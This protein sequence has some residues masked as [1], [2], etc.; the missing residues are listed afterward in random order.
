[1]SKLT[2]TAKRLALEVRSAADDL[3]VS[4]CE[5][6]AEVLRHMLLSSDCD[7]CH[8]HWLEL[9]KKLDEA[10]ARKDDV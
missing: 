3:D 7:K 2:E 8:V 4:V 6:E 9:H 5:L 1:M 10:L